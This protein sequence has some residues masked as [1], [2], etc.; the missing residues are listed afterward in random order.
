LVKKG[1][2]YRLLV[3]EA[4][5][6]RSLGEPRHKCVDNIKMDLGEIG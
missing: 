6:K 2:A 5:G 3:K 1:N 4:E